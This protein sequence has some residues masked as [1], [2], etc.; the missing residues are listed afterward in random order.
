MADS[1]DPVPVWGRPPTEGCEA[2]LAGG[3]QGQRVPVPIP[4]SALSD[5][6]STAALPGLL[7]HAH[8][9]TTLGSYDITS[10]ALERHAPYQVAG[11]LAGWA[12]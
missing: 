6:P 5:P 12:G 1:R 7:R 8:S 3:G 10:E 4:P 2:V 11:F 9:E